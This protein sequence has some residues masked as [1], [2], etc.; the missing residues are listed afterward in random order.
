MKRKLIPIAGALIAGLVGVAEACY[1]EYSTIC[2]RQDTVVGYVYQ[3]DRF[4][5][6]KAATDWIGWVQYYGTDGSPLENTL[7]YCH[8]PG[9]YYDC[10]SGQRVDIPDMTDGSPGFYRVQDGVPCS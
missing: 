6:I 1:Y 8:G 4:L 2:E 5:E 10:R 3:C 9:Y 7:S